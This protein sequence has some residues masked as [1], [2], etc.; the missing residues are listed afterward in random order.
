MV[1]GGIAW[2]HVITRGQHPL[3]SWVAKDRAPDCAR[4]TD[5]RLC[6]I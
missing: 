3:R 5:T 4:S 1:W 6:T 2:S